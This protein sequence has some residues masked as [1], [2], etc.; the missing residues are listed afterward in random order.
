MFTWTKKQ[1][2]QQ[3][4]AHIHF[5]PHICLLACGRCP[6]PP[7][8]CSQSIEHLTEE[9]RLRIYQIKQLLF[10]NHFEVIRDDH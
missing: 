1:N 6:I 5:K 9:M 4:P 2:S 10:I 7:Y 8:Q 3:S